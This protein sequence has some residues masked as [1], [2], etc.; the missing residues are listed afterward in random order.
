MDEQVHD[1]AEGI[2]VKIINPN[3]PRREQGTEKTYDCP[4]E[5]ECRWQEQ[6]GDKL[7]PPRL[8]LSMGLDPRVVLF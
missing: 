5:A 3:Q 1:A 2:P 7:C 6:A 4:K 8:A